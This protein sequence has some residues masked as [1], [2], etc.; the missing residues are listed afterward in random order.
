M[1][2]ALGPEAAF[3]QEA[4]HFHATLDGNRALDEIGI[5]AISLMACVLVGG[6]LL[7]PPADGR[8]RR[9]EKFGHVGTT[10]QCL[11]LGF[12]Q[13]LFTEITLLQ[14]ASEVAQ[15]LLALRQAVQ[16]ALW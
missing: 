8:P 5:W 9:I 16:V 15:K 14:L 13:R 12:G 4:K 1:S 10:D 11:D 6:W 3:D 7:N 2:S